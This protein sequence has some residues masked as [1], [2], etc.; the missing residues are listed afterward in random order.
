MVGTSLIVSIGVFW[1]FN[2][3]LHIYLILPSLPLLLVARGVFLCPVF[4]GF[5]LA[6]ANSHFRQLASTA[7]ID[8]RGLL[9]YNTNRLVMWFGFHMVTALVTA[10]ITG[11]V[12]TLARVNGKDFPC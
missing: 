9:C 8:T 4:P 11:L 2:C 6:R 7:T 1:C 5:T 12:F 3:F 10:T